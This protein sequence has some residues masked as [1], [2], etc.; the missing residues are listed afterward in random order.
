V[1]APRGFEVRLPIVATL[2]DTIISISNEIGCQWA[3]ADLEPI[4]DNAD[5]DPVQQ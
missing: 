4:W 5:H 2:R 1:F 3:E